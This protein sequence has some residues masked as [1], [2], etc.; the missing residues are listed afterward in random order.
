[1]ANLLPVDKTFR[2]SFLPF[3]IPYA[4]YVAIEAL[5][6]SILSPEMKQ[7]IKLI[8]VS[9]AMAWFFKWYRFGKLNPKLVGISLVATPIALIIVNS[10]TAG[11]SEFKMRRPD[12]D[13][14][15]SGTGQSKG[16]TTA[17]VYFDVDK[18]RITEI[19][20][21]ETRDSAVETNLFSTTTS[22]KTTSTVTLVSE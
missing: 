10:T 16:A 4:L 9:A 13:M 14:E 15:I 19:V 22:M 6:V 18:G 20:S 7:I 21:E 12:Q 11:T 17:L 1:M 8:A 3:F 5:P 2:Q